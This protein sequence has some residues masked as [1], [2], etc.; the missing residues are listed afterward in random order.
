MKTFI[1]QVCGFEFTDSVA[2]GEAWREAKMKAA[3]SNAAIYRLIIN[4]ESV[5]QEVYTKAGCFLSTKY[6]QPEQVLIF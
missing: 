2:F 6:V 3:A 4:G 1:Y 5:K